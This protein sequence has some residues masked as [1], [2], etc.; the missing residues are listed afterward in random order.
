MPKKYDLITELYKRTLGEITKDAARWQRF[1]LAT[2]RLSMRSV[3]TRQPAPSLKY[4]G[5]N[6]ADG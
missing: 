6:S 5:K 2:R 3:R 1:R 4:G